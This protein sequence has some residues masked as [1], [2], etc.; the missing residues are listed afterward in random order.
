M[1]KKEIGHAA[2]KRILSF[3]LDALEELFMVPVVAIGLAGIAWFIIP[4]F[5]RVTLVSQPASASVRQ[6]IE[7][8]SPKFITIKGRFDYSGIRYRCRQNEDLGRC[9]PEEYLY[10]FFDESSGEGVY[11]MTPVDP[12]VFIVMHPGETAVTAV[13]E[14]VS[15]NDRRYHLFIDIAQI[16]ERA[17]MLLKAYRKIDMNRPAIGDLIELLSNKGDAP[18]RVNE[19]TYLNA[20]YSIYRGASGYFLG[21]FAIVIV[22]AG[23]PLIAFGA[24]SGVENLR[25]KHRDGP[26][27]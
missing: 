25:R 15:K 17:N 13:T 4:D 9:L 14:G 24:A 7:Q 16:S 2:M 19:E 12:E 21:V 8:R 23:M 5:F 6:V 1:G 22:L 3:L 26:G 18:L 10:P 11:V 20:D 27:E